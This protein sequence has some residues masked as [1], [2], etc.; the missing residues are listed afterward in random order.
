MSGFTKVKATR[1]L[2]FYRGESESGKTARILIKGPSGLLGEIKW[3]AR[4][5]QYAFFPH[6]GTVWNQECMAD[7]MLMIDSLM[8]ERKQL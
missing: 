5:R 8:L 4:W 3:F 7:V 2:D 1:Y 6:E